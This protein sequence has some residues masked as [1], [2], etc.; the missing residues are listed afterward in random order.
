VALEVASSDEALRLVTDEIFAS[1]HRAAA[2]RLERGG[3]SAAQADELATVFV[4]ALEGG[5]LLSRVA[6]DATK[7]EVIGRWVVQLVEDALAG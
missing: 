4:A 7:M 6:K 5:F 3:L 1:W 2:S